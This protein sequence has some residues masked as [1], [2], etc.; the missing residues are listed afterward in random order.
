MKK[1][2]STVLG[3][4]FCVC[5]YA[6]NGDGSADNPYQIGN[7]DEL[8]EFASI[9]NEGSVDAN[10]VLTADIV[11]NNLQPELF[12]GNYEGVKL[13]NPICGKL[14]EKYDGLFDG[15]GHSISGLVVSPNKDLYSFGFFGTCSE[16]SIVKNLIIKDSYFS[17][18]N[19]IGAICGCNHGTIENCESYNSIVDGLNNSYSTPYRGGISGANFNKIRH[20]YSTAT[21][22]SPEEGIGG[23]AGYN[24]GSIAECG[25]GG[26]LV[27][28]TAKT[29]AG[30][31]SFSNT[32]VI[33]NCYSAG[34]FE[35]DFKDVC[36]ITTV[37]FVKNC[38]YD[39]TKCH[40]TQ[41]FSVPQPYNTKDFTS[42]K[43]CFLL[44]SN[45]TG[46]SIVWHQDLSKDTLPLFVGKEVY[47]SSPCV[48]FYSNE[49]DSLE[50]NHEMENNV[51]VHCDYHV[52]KYQNLTCEI[53]GKDQRLDEDGTFLIYTA[54]DLYDFANQVNE[55]QN[56][57]L[58]AKLMNDIVVNDVD[59]SNTD[60]I[61]DTLRMWIPIG[62]ESLGV[63]NACFDGNGYSISGIFCKS[64]DYYYLGLFAENGSYSTIKNL[65]IVNSHFENEDV[66]GNAGSITA[67]NNG[68]VVNC[69]NY[70]TVKGKKNVGGI[71]GENRLATIYGCVNHGVIMTMSARGEAGGITAHNYQG[72]IERCG[73]EGIVKGSVAGGITGTSGKDK[74]DGP[75]SYPQINY[76]YNIGEITGKTHAGGL[77]GDDFYKISHCFNAGKVSG[78]QYYGSISGGKFESYLPDPDSVEVTKC[79]TLVGCDSVLN[80]VEETS[81]PEPYD[82]TVVDSATFASGAVAFLLNEGTTDGTQPFYQTIEERK[83]ALRAMVLP[84]DNLDRFPVLDSLHGTVYYNEEISVY[85]NYEMEPTGFQIVDSNNSNAVYVFG[86]RVV[87]P[88][89]KD[90]LMVYSIDGKIVR[91][92]PV[93]TNVQNTEFVL[94]KGI[95]MIVV[96]GETFKINIAK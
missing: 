70:A 76:C 71:C 55:W 30:G 8:Y 84:T 68:F 7:V 13:W 33:E 31:I 37:S 20:C 74:G 43:I 87:V 72:L 75:V 16:K 29:S 83:P 59:L 78:E 3:L 23:I 5:G 79:F 48:G 65:R 54:D 61:A 40:Q 58:N 66:Y 94:N 38:Y 10:G 53:C 24:S 39:S 85:Y 82:I 21:I 81:I 15:K 67:N 47:Q 41:K 51:C 95:Y 35:G 12:D 62:A 52:H 96:D 28:K 18:N 6:I 19:D 1:T 77:A 63:Y 49:K 69:E 86:N 93:K 25:F 60:S 57:T 27:A 22:K 17:A 50:H 9:V 36:G 64:S 4:L 44:N 56:L 90:K 89:I 45:S 14:L 2:L 32:G 42:G 26:V 88:E 46:G 92:M 34:S 11:V 91:F 80:G 73:N